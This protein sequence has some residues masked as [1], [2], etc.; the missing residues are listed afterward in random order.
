[1]KSAYLLTGMPGTGK[2]SLIKQVAGRLAG[3]AGGFYTEEI[4]DQSG[5]RQGFRLVTLDGRS[6]PLAHTG[7]RSPHRVSKYGVDI[8]GLDT[9]GIGSLRQAAD[10]DGIVIIDEIGRME[11]FSENF[12]NT[13]LEI[14]ESGRKVLGTIMLRPDP[15][16]DALKQKSQVKV[17]TLTRSNRSQ[18]YQEIAEWLHL[19]IPLQ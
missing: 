4:R 19:D 14:I 9:L 11:L 3:R 15:F 10:R 16:A 8:Q 5:I 7:I 13:V 1:M 12:R 18:V 2:T 6:A 17:I